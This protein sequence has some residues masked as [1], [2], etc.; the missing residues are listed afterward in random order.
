MFLIYVGGTKEIGI[1]ATVK[2]TWENR[3]SLFG[4]R[5]YTTFGAM[6]PTVHGMVVS[7][8]K[9]ETG[10]EL[11]VK[12]DHPYEGMDGLWT[13]DFYENAQN[14]VG[15]HLLSDHWSETMTFEEFVAEADDIMKAIGMHT[16]AAEWTEDL[17]EYA[18]AEGAGQ[19]PREMA[20]DWMCNYDV[21]RAEYPTNVGEPT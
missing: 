20:V 2:V 12:F 16:N 11:Y 14:Q 4:R 17:Q 13:S 9:T 7:Q 5:V 15:S 3:L 6:F 19:T 21:L 10:I 18:D 1:M 8:R